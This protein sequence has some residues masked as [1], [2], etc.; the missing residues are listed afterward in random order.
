IYVGKTISVQSTSTVGTT[1]LPT[2]SYK[3]EDIGLTLKIK[4]RVSS[5]DK[6]GLDVE[7]I[8]ENLQAPDA[9]GNPVTT[10]QE[11]KTQI[12]LRSGEDILIGGLVRNYIL[13]SVEKIPLLSD[14]P[15]I[16]DWL[17]TYKKE[18]RVKDN[19][20]VI[21]TPYVID[22]SEQLSELQKSLGE[23]ANL[24]DRYNI[25]VIDA[26]QERIE[27]NDNNMSNN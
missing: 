19:L 1:G 21:L 7:V 18:D 9:V 16:G 25:E 26:M 24:Q 20:V 22:K 11:V 2:A 6:V 14:I 8:L 23:L 15:W 12:I 5:N 4:P 27:Q 10:K 13:K 17:F 3:R